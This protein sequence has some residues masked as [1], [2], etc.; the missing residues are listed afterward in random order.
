MMVLMVV[1]PGAGGRRVLAGLALHVRGKVPASGGLPGQPAAW[2]VS[3]PGAPGPALHRGQTD[4]LYYHGG[5]VV[6][7]VSCSVIMKC[8]TVQY[9]KDL[10]IS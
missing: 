7:M 3:D 5:I 10:M 8:K 9:R 4:L 1:V 6:F 2:H